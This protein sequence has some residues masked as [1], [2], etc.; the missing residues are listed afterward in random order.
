[1]LA[2]NRRYLSARHEARFQIIVAEGTK[3]WALSWVIALVSIHSK[4]CWRGTII[5]VPPDDIKICSAGF[6]NRK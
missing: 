5:A 4:H 2:S 1:V 6:R 3:A